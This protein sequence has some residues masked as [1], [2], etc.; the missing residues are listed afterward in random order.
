MHKLIILM[1]IILL[2]SKRDKVLDGLVTCI[3]RVSRNS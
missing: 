3:K 1:L 2:Q